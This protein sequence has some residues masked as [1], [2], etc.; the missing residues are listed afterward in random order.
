[1]II[2]LATLDDPDFKEDA[3]R[4]EIVHPLLTA[5]GYA[6][7]GKNRIIRS[8]SLSHPFV[9]IGT[10]KRPITVI[11]DYLLSVDEKYRWV[12][13]A[14]GPRES[15]TSGDN[16]LQA[17]SYAIHPEIR[18]R[19]FA[20]CNGKE[21]ALF[22]V[23][24]REPLLLFPLAELAEFWRPL[25]DLLRPEAFRKNTQPKPA[26]P[27]PPFDYLA[28][29]PPKEVA[30]FQKQSAKRHHGV[31]GYF[32]RQIWSVVQ[33]Y[34]STFTKP[35][36]IILDPFGG[37]GVTYIEALV[38]GRKAIQVDTN[39]LCKFVV[40]TLVSP[41]NLALL[42][43][44]FEKV[45]AEFQR[46]RPNTDGEADN[47][48]ETLPY[49]KGVKLP[50]SSDV[51]TVDQLFSRM[52]LA[53]LALLKSIISRVKDGSSRAHLLLMFSGLLNKINLT[54]HAS[55]ART[56]GG[57]DS[58]IFRYYRYRIAHTSP[59]LDVA[60]VFRLRFNRVL[61]AKAELAPYLAATDFSSSKV[62]KGT[63]TDLSGIEDRSVDYIY[64][65]PP[66]GSKIPYLDLS[67]MWNAWLDLD[68][69]AEDFRNEAI[70]GGEQRK[71]KKEYESLLSES[72]R[73]M[74]RVLKFDRW[75]SF[76]FAHKDPAYW[77]LIVET[78]EAVGFEYAGVTRQNNGQASFKKRQ[79]PFTVLSGQLIIN[80]RKVQNP[81]SIMAVRLGMD[82]ADII[83]ETI[84]GTIAAHQ[85][86]SLEQINDGLVIRGLELGFLHILSQQYNDLTP[87]LRE[88][89][90]YEEIDDKYHIKKNAKFKTHVDVRLRVRYYLLS[91][92]RRMEHNGI[93]PKFDDIVLS[94]I[95]LLK[96]GITPEN[97]TVLSVLE[98]LAERDT[99]DR[100]RL[101]EDGQGTLDF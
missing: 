59:R 86:A 100:W 20:L 26:A 98:G 66:Y 38:L 58:A 67:T 44:D 31:H 13:D 93:H 21:F 42:E 81:K 57:G 36:D 43:H 15:V 19:L 99:N 51:T 25:N 49:P 84:E 96:N 45:E 78:A 35:G 17:Y 97:Q 7:S 63:A 60:K 69:T 88:K 79:N 75:M 30:I 11:P 9:M 52:Q 47:L 68:V 22:E 95:P 101:K 94:I 27:Q 56:E 70:E 83:E 28:I 32:T 76:V 50:K 62:L 24:N 3:V 12:L 72:I 48:I 16:V 34:V 6:S 54:Y 92:L 18:T 53:E 85:G 10:T 61:G 2:D 23:E 55:T 73:E 65:D 8:K 74:Y 64:T 5:L 91:Y 1:M 37:S 77:H 4:E 33:K 89:F 29:K 40:E 71:S 80:F 87:L 39:P 46:R 82:I 14:K 90:Q 41:V